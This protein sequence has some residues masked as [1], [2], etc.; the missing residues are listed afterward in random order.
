[1]NSFLYERE[2]LLLCPGGDQSITGKLTKLIVLD[3]PET[4]YLGNGGTAEWWW[5]GAADSTQ[6]PRPFSCVSDSSSLPASF[7]HP[8]LTFC[9]TSS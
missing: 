4:V 6:G 8:H 3:F 2:L 9:L 5:T 7:V 1:M